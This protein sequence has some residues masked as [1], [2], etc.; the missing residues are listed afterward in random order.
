MSVVLATTVHDPGGRM[1]EQTARALPILR[2]IFASIAAQVTHASSDTTLALL[3]EAGALI[4]QDPAERFAGYMKLGR[5]RRESVELAL[6]CEQLLIMFCDFDRVIHWADVYPDELA[7]TAARLPEQDFTVMGRTPRAFASH[8]RVQ[9]DTESIVNHVFAMT[10]GK[11]WDITAAARGLSRR[12]AKAILAGCP[13][14]SIGTDASWPLFVQQ[15]GGF[16]MGYL[17]TEGLEFET[18][19]RF[20]DEVAAAGGMA[21]WIARMDA[22]PRNWAQRLEM[23]QLSVQAMLPYV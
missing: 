17:A 18:A 19:D 20:G 2:E 4:R 16:S 13:D 11:P 6:Q 21:Q 8:P 1:L 23:A 10:R 14:E 22:D 5:P 7:A 3:H 9:R 15:A 12:A